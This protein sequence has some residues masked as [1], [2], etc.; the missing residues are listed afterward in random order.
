MRQ[1]RIHFVDDVG[2]VVNAVEIER[3]TD[4]A[5]IQEA[6]RVDI[7]S[8]GAGF[9][10]GT[11]IGSCIGIAVALNVSTSK[12]AA[13]S[14][15]GDDDYAVRR[16]AIRRVGDDGEGTI[17]LPK[18]R[19]LM[20]S[21]AVARCLMP[22]RLRGHEIKAMRKIMKLT[23]ADLAKRL[24]ERTAPETVARWESE[25]QAM[26]GYAEKVLR[27]LICEALAKEAPGVSYKASMIVDL[28]VMDPWKTDKEFDVPY[29]GLE[30][31]QMKEQ[32]GSLIEAWN[33]KM[34]A[35]A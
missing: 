8:A 18:L 15:S 9:D 32:S 23:M 3:G 27:L 34:A 24:D 35:A 25:A 33:V 16:A 30:L 2:R 28:K 19:E 1:Y 10:I 13:G 6:H 22:I 11:S 14:S 21:A 7:P 5:A 31:I 4:D 12:I 26:G 20:A 17:E 29:V